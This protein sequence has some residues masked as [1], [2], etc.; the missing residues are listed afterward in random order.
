MGTINTSRWLLG[1]S[2]AAI[3]IWLIEGAA[4]VFYME[5]MQTAMQAHNLSLE[6]GPGMWLITILVSLIAGLVSVFFYA[7]ARP[8]FGPGPK[9]AVIVA[10]AFWIGSYMLSLLGYQM[11]GLYPASMLVMWGAIGLVELIVAT[12][13]G[14]WL[15]RE[16]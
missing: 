14:A 1:G 15:Y 8:R 10:V 16:A 3:I 12:L 6:M 4:S 9:T 2:V 5:D 11:L 7:A 13:V